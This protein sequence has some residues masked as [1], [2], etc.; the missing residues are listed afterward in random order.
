MLLGQTAFAYYNPQTGRFLSRDPARELGF[1]VTQ[2]ASLG[3]FRTAGHEISAP[4]S[5]GT[6]RDS[7]R[8]TVPVF[9]TFNRQPDGLLDAQEDE[10][11]ERDESIRM[12]RQ[13]ELNL[14]AFVM[15]N[16]VNRVDCLGLKSKVFGSGK[17]CVDKNCKGTDL[18]TLKYLPEVNPPYT[19]MPMPSP[20]N[21]VDA[22]A[23]YAM[24]VW[25]RK[26]PDNGKLT[27]VCNCVSIEGFRYIKWPW[28]LGN[29]VGWDYG[30]PRPPDFPVPW[31]SP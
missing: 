5:D 27:V 15:Q 14:Y 10:S 1:Q 18:S 12:S 7:A 4:V 6:I 3:V 30:T 13:D 2:R 9:R 21:C 22:D 26:I 8:G 19:L 24:G 29:M 31:P 25:A 20:G 28:W 23:F 11:I 17:V 16:P